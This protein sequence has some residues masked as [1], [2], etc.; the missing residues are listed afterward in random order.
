MKLTTINLLPGTK[1]GIQLRGHRGT[2]VS[3]W[4]RIFQITTIT[5][6]LKPKTPANFK[7]VISGTTFTASWDAVTQNVDNSPI[8]DLKGYYVY[9]RDT[10][11]DGVT[12]KF[13]TADT[14]LNLTKD[15]NS[16]YF[17]DIGTLFPHPKGSLAAKATA[18]DNSGNES[19]PTPEIT[20]EHERPT[21]PTNFVAVG[22]Q[23]GVQ[24]SW[25]AST[26]SDIFGYRIHMSMVDGSFT[27]DDTNFIWA[28]QATSTTYLTFHYGI[29]HYFK[30]CAYDSFFEDSDFV[31][32]D[33]IPRSSFT[34]DVDPPPTPTGF[35]LAPALN[36]TDS[37]LMDV[38]ATWTAVDADDLDGYR[39]RYRITASSD[40]WQFVQVPA[41]V[42]TAVVRGLLVGTTYDFQ[43]E[44]FDF[45][46]NKSEFSA[47][48]TT[49]MTN[50]APSKPAIP[51]LAGTMLAFAVSH[52]MLKAAGG[53]LESDV[54]ALKVY[55]NS[56]NT[57]VGATSLQTINV[58]QGSPVAVSDRIILPTAATGSSQYIFV[59]AVDSAGLEGPNSDGVAVTVSTL[60]GTYIQDATITSAK[61]QDLAANKITA[62]TGIINDLTISSK[63]TIGTGG[64]IQ[65]NLY[66]TS[67]G[68]QGF[69]LDDTNLIIKSGQI[70]A[71]ALRIQ[72]SANVVPPQYA[73]FE[74]ATAFYIVGPAGGTAVPNQSIL[75]DGSA[76][77]SITAAPDATQKKYETQSLK[78]V[79]SGAS[80][81]TV[82]LSSLSTSYPVILDTSK[83]YIISGYIYCATALTVGL[84]L[85]VN[86]GITTTVSQAIPATT[87]TRISAAVPA[88]TA[89]SAQI[90]LTIPVGTVYVDAL[91]VEEQISSATTPSAWKP[92]GV[93]SIDGGIIRT[94]EIRSATNI[95]ING[96][97]Q[98][99]WSINT[100]GSVQFGNA[101]IRGS[102]VVGAAADGAASVVQ[103][104]NFDATH[105][106]QINS[107]GAAVFRN[108]IIGSGSTFAGS[109]SNATGT[110][111][112]VPINGFD[113]VTGSIGALKI[114]AND[115]DATR[116][117]AGTLTSSSGVFGPINVGHLVSNAGANSITG[118]ATLEVFTNVAAAPAFRVNYGYSYFAN[119]VQINGILYG[120]SVS[121][122]PSIRSGAS[123]YSYAD[124]PNGVALRIQKGQIQQNGL[125]VLNSGYVTL[126]I[127]TST[128]GLSN[129]IAKTSSS[130]TI[131]KNIDYIVDES[132][133]TD[134]LLDLPVRQFRYKLGD[135]TL[136]PG[137]IADEVAQYYPVAAYI[138]ANGQVENWMERHIIP[139]LLDLIQKLDKR[140]KF[141]EARQA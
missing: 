53:R 94:G 48:Q 67:S 65:S 107:G 1:Y 10:A 3:A 7:F 113:I 40:P 95:T 74:F 125:A 64:K 103:S 52:N 37:S 122:G 23:D 12:K 47:I 117:K 86:G 83:K 141:L 66:T 45:S 60:S 82:T 17:N 85:V 33:A 81:R 104:Y 89:E 72:N 111:N 22:I 93:T 2:E 108:A 68:N 90:Q 57:F 98:P 36:A 136:V 59:T 32:A 14:S 140:V 44:A 63:L 100:Q 92:P 118:T 8:Y 79:N 70:E 31:S 77:G 18:V 109:L 75:V 101:L 61:I 112:G 49:S 73:G 43:I 133:N 20:V 16:A 99:A 110:I 88:P 13:F 35:T 102:L 19:D 62:G 121:T 97:V 137:F 96:N 130:R 9:I 106:W 76:I 135:G 5:K 15:D 87:W 127:G 129:C 50:T 126:G 69:Y 119:D 39:V 42:L 26:S 120:G 4:S 78:I 25:D 128:T 91:Q 80:S 28:G 30:L 139:G 132:L 116:I 56:S 46:A 54:V 124:D 29:R 105:G 138:N 114:I 84:S 21:A 41:D 123:F 6:N 38:T 24:L 58:S 115:I 55:Y 131:K 27:P 34:V 11:P 51:T 71:S 134:K